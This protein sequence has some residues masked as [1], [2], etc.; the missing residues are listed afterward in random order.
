MHYYWTINLLNYSLKFGTQLRNKQNFEFNYCV[1]SWKIVH[2]NNYKTVYSQVSY[3]TNNERYNRK[4]F[5]SA[6]LGQTIN[7]PSLTPS[8][9]S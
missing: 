6:I 7:K 3:L 9:G 1:E 2:H 4:R 5:K 8:S